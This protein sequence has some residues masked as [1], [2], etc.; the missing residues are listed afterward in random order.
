MKPFRIENALAP[1]RRRPSGW[2]EMSLRD[3]P[4]GNLPVGNLSEVRSARGAPGEGDNA[5]I[6]SELSAIGAET[7]TAALRILTMVE[8]LTELLEARGLDKEA[9]PILASILEAC[10][11]QDLTGQRVG[12]II[13]L[14]DARAIPGTPPKPP[15]PDAPASPPVPRLPAASDENDLGRRLINGPR[16]AGAEGHMNQSDIDVLFD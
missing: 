11:F 1:V 10:S 14:L 4:V 12:K 9:T 16:V 3:M 7:C 15:C 5:L 6:L 2:P 13:A 8:R